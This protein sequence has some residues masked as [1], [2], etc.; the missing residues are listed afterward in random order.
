MKDERVFFSLKRDVIDRDYCV[1]CGSC[2]GFC[3]RIGFNEEK[4]RPELVKE[5]VVGCSNCYLNC[6]AVTN[7]PHKSLFGGEKVDPLL[8]CYKEIKSAKSKLP[9]VLTAAQDGGAATSIL[10]AALEKKRIDAA[11]VVR[12]DESWKPFPVIAFSKEELISAAGSKYSPS[13]N[14]STLAKIHRML[15]ESNE[16]KISDIAIVDVG[17][18]TRGLRNLEF[19]LLY[20]LGF[21]PYSDLKVYSIG[22]FCTG[23]FDYPKLASSLKDLGDIS[24]IEVK[25]S[26]CTVT[27]CERKE[28]IELEK[29]KKNFLG[30]CRFCG[31]YTA[32]LSDLSIGSVG[33]EI[34][35]STVITRSGEG[36]AMLKDAQQLG[37]LE[38]KSEVDID[39][40]K[41]SAQRKKKIARTSLENAKKKKEFYP[42][43]LK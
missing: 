9:S 32:E 16:T 18:H 3:N 6:P 5:C 28:L 10:A 11:I 23:S 15:D 1:V 39:Q 8:G 29:L 20:S 19:N 24:K 40:I 25:R 21:S 31:D 22:L 7:F 42:L 4:Q 30:L 33:S 38:V 37:Y 26:R 27:R 43:Y 14:L 35:W 12:R 36:W 34:G 17:C 41:A 2:F 13:P